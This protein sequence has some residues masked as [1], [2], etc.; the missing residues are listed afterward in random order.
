M[1]IRHRM[2]EEFPIDKGHLLVSDPWLK[3]PHFHRTV[4]L[5]TEH[6]AE[7]SIGFIQNKPLT[8]TV[9]DVLED[10]PSPELPLF[11]GGPV[12]TDT[13]HYLLLFGEKVGGQPLQG[14][15]SWGGQF[16]AIR[17]LATNGELHPL[18][19][20]FFIGYSGWGPHQLQ[21]EFSAGA[22]IGGP[23]FDLK[24]WQIPPADLWRTTLRNMGADFIS[25]A[26]SPEDP[27]LN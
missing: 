23:E 19:I 6:E 14:G 13:L 8:L 27:S 17:L 25:I 21:S 7:C 18:N 10:F 9:G 11:L 22:W 24:N 1:Y 12:E 26:N 3:D 2:S 16:E 5:L 15:L 20:R 4:I